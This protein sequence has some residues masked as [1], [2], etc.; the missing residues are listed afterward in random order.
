MICESTG[1]G[2]ICGGERFLES[3]AG[4]IEGQERVEGRQGKKNK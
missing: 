4:F 3:N 1:F 2:L